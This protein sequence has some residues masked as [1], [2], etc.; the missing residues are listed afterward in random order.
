M[1]DNIIS[2]LI[3]EA[4]KSS[5]YRKHAACIL[6][7]T[8]VIALGHNYMP[9]IEYKDKRSIHAE[10]SAILNLPKKYKLKKYNLRMIVIRISTYGDRLMISKPCENCINCIEK[11]SNINKIN[12]SV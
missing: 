8:K 11:I 1:D 4:N 3:N 5:M 9:K 7:G 2:K 6:N 10:H 12:F